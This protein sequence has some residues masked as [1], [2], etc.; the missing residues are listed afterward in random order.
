MGHWGPDFSGVFLPP[1][2]NFSFSFECPVD[3][4]ARLQV[5]AVEEVLANILIGGLETED[6]GDKN[7]LLCEYAL[8]VYIPCVIWYAG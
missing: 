4:A 6:L 3:E 5:V 7:F 2:T 8:I 1:L